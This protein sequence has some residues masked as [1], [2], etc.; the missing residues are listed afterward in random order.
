MYVCGMF[1][2]VNL[3]A[4]NFWCN[5]SFTDPPHGGFGET[6]TLSNDFFLG[7]EGISISDEILLGAN[8]LGK[9]YHALRVIFWRIPFAPGL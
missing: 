4:F 2:I 9:H 3:E 7:G 1:Y 5:I 6:I 8:L